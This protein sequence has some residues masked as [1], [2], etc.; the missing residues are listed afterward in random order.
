ML[1]PLSGGVASRLPLCST[2]VQY[3]PHI[4]YHISRQNATIFDRKANSSIRGE[5]RLPRCCCFIFLVI[6]ARLRALCYRATG[7]MEA[8]ALRA[9]VWVELHLPT[10]HPL[11]FCLMKYIHSFQ[12]TAF[13]RSA[14]KRRYIPSCRASSACVPRWTMRPLSTTRI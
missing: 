7:Q 8:E 14:M 9:V 11:P 5:F 13:S 3:V 6:A 4:E 10:V 1:H 12:P 2:P